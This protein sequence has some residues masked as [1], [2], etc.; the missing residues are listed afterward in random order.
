ML[1]YDYSP[2]E[3]IQ[4][5]FLRRGYKK[6]GGTGQI[7]YTEF[8]KRSSSKEERMLEVEKNFQCMGEERV[9]GH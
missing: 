4:I 6:A 1:R 9:E 3:L 7:L 2:Q 5:E 8:F